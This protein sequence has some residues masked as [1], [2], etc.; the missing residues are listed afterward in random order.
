MA[1]AK[2]EPL[3]PAEFSFERYTDNRAADGLD[4]GVHMQNGDLAQPATPAVPWTPDWIDSRTS[5]LTEYVV[6]APSASNLA[7]Y[8]AAPD[9]SFLTYSRNFNEWFVRRLDLD[10]GDDPEM[11]RHWYPGWRQVVVKDNP[12]VRAFIP[13]ATDSR[14]MET[15]LRPDGNWSGDGTFQ[16]VN[17]GSTTTTTTTTF[18]TRDVADESTELT[19]V[20][21]GGSV[22]DT[23][24]TYSPTGAES[25]ATQVALDRSDEPEPDNQNRWHLQY[26]GDDS[27]KIVDDGTGRA[28]QVTNESYTAPDGTVTD[29]N[30]VVATPGWWD[31]REQYWTLKEVDDGYQLVNAARPDLVLEVT[32]DV[33]TTGGDRLQLRAAPANDDDPKQTWLL[34]VPAS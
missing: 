3:T 15:L 1:G 27:V 24:W 6:P 2:P 13:P 8:N 14:G 30:N 33:G 16:F 31:A 28:L 12:G 32:N 23:G 25:A 29:G 17:S 20:G 4:N 9:T 18:Q 5:A 22:I 7:A 11:I 19:S 26:L 21:A 34:N 10:A